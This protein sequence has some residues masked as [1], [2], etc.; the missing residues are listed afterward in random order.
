MS[1]VIYIWHM[2][3]YFLRVIVQKNLL[4]QMVNLGRFLQS[5]LTIFF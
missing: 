1:N 3:F 2:D 5:L 4:Y